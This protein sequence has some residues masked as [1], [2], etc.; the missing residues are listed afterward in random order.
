MKTGRFNVTR[1]QQFYFAEMRK[2]AIIARISTVS[3]FLELFIYEADRP[4]CDQS[5][6]DLAAR[7]RMIP[8][9]FADSHKSCSLKD[10][11]RKNM[12]NI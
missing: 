2:R 7:K 6:Y 10:D 9:L 5:D 12:Q 4:V 11:V 1:C 8:T 3:Y